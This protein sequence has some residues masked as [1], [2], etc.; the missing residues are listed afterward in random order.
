MLA[1][2]TASV[3]TFS[4]PKPPPNLEKLIPRIAPRPVFL[5]NA[6][7]NEVDHKAPEYFAAAGEP[8]QQWLVPKGGHAGGYAAMPR[9]YE[10]RVV[11]FLDRSL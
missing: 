7:H 9:E 6:I 5:I 4:D 2:K 8:K 11:D 1:I 3:A 10:R